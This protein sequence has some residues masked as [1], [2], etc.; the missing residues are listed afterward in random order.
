MHFPMLSLLSRFEQE[1]TDIRFNHQLPPSLSFFLCAC[2]CSRVINKRGE[3]GGGLWSIA[4]D[5][6]YTNAS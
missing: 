5:E 2:D 6:I 3:Q 1:D 4:V